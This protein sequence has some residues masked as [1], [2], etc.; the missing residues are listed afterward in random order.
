MSL[1]GC[2]CGD[3]GVLRSNAR[4]SVGAVTSVLSSHMMDDMSMQTDT[5]GYSGNPFPNYFE[6]ASPTPLPF[7]PEQSHASSSYR[8]EDAMDHMN[9]VAAHPEYLMPPQELVSSEIMMNPMTGLGMD[10]PSLPSFAPSS[11]MLHPM[12]PPP[13]V[14]AL[15]VI[16]VQPCYL[17]HCF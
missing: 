2:G 7:L 12:A 4:C 16:H 14:S 10:A 8:M 9:H 17:C 13:L 11:Q 3:G 15:C 5:A 6:K 1:R